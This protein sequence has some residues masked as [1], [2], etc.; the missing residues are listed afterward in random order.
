[1]KNRKV[2]RIK[3]WIAENGGLKL[4]KFASPWE[5]LKNLKIGRIES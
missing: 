2:V 4:R 1:L 3:V 5:R